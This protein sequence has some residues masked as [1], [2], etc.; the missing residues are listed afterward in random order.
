MTRSDK[1]SSGR[2]TRPAKQSAHEKAMAAL[3]LTYRQLAKLVKRKHQSIYWNVT[4]GTLPREQPYR[5][6]YIKALGLQ[7]ETP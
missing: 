2:F 1:T 3:G 5:R 4:R 6:R 7:E